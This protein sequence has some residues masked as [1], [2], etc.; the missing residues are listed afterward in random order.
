MDTALRTVTP[1][2]AGRERCKTK[3]IYPYESL[4]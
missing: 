1:G 2:R 4:A 3:E